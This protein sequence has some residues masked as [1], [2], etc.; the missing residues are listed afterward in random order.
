MRLSATCHILNRQLD[1]LRPE[2]VSSERVSTQPSD[3]FAWR[4]HLSNLAHDFQLGHQI[5][6][7]CHARR[8]HPPLCRAAVANQ[9]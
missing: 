8:G 5:R 3:T 1:G 9:H 6:P 7:T 4:E 2:R